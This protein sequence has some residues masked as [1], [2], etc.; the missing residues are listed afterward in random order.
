MFEFWEILTGWEEIL[1][2]VL[3]NT[4][5]NLHPYSRLIRTGSTNGGVLSVRRS[6]FFFFLFIY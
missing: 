3:L 5:K 4:E 6:K 1:D 2:K